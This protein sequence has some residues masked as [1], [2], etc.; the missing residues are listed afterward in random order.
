[1]TWVDGVYNR[2]PHTDFMNNIREYKKFQSL[3]EDQ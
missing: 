1:M 3:H 2:G